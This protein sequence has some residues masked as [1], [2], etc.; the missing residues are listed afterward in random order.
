MFC[1][2]SSTHCAYSMICWGILGSLFALKNTYILSGLFA[3][4]IPRSFWNVNFLMWVRDLQIEANVF[5][6]EEHLSSC[7]SELEILGT[8][9]SLSLLA[10]IIKDRS[11]WL[12]S[13]IGIVYNGVCY[14]IGEE[15]TDGQLFGPLSRGLLSTQPF[16]MVQATRSGHSAPLLS[17]RSYYGLI[18]GPP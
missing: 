13:W 1:E 11:L 18:T 7:T 9:Q 5:P 12:S 17:F 10:Y 8:Q 2:L 3:S 14:R 6:S 15:A 16:P 4:M